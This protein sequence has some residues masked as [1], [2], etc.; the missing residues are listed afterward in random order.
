MPRVFANQFLGQRLETQPCSRTT[1]GLNEEP[2]VHLHWAL[3]DGLTHGIAGQNGQGADFPMIPNRWLVVRLWDQTETK[4]ES[5]LQFRAWIV[6]SDTITDKDTGA[7]WLSLGAGNPS[8]QDRQDYSVRVGRQFLLG[9]WPGERIRPKARSQSS[10]G[11]A[12][13]GVQWHV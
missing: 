11:P 12:L 10:G 3:P 13:G 9:A 7:V 4:P 8:P 1:S 6:E 5:S 2:G